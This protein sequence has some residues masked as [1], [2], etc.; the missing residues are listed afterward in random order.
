MSEERPKSP[1]NGVPLPIGRP[2]VPGEEQ[3]EKSSKAGKASAQARRQRKSL[4][5]DLLLALSEEVTQK[6]GKKAPVQ[7]ALSVSLIKAA[8]NGNVRAYEIIRDTIG[9]KPAEVMNVNMPDPSI[10]EEVKEYLKA[11]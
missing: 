8:L 6:D 10:M 1:I 2:F 4:K 5:E 3:R 7:K 11:K 9:E